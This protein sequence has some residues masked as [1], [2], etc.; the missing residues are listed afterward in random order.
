MKSDCVRLKAGFVIY[1]ADILEEYIGKANLVL[2]RGKIMY[3][4]IQY[5]VVVSRVYIIELYRRVDK[6]DQ[7]KEDSWNVPKIFSLCI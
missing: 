7:S 2:D 4:Y 3:I 1:Q 5:T 6:E